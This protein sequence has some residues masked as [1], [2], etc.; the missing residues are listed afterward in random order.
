[1]SAELIPFIDQIIEEDLSEESVIWQTR[2]E[3]YIQRCRDLQN[4]QHKSILLPGFS[5]PEQAKLAMIR[6]EEEL[7]KKR[8][9]QSIYSTHF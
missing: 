8:Q 2:A 9:R 1:V 7:A 5:I 4:Q 3:K 6:E